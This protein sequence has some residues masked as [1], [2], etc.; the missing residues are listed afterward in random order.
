MTVILAQPGCPSCPP[1]VSVADSHFITR[2][3]CDPY[4]RIIMLCRL[5]THRW[6]QTAASESLRGLRAQPRAQRDGLRLRVPSGRWKRIVRHSQD[7]CFAWGPSATSALSLR[8]VFTQRKREFGRVALGVRAQTVW[9]RLAGQVSV[10]EQRK[11]RNRVIG[12][13]SYAP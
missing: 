9:L 6:V 4:I 8:G 13:N 7:C 2:L 10:A 1:G 3:E 12:P 11:R 5:L